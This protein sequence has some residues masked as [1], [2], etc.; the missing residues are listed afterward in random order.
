[1]RQ[2]LPEL[3]DARRQR[4]IREYAL[5][6]YDA[7]QLTLSRA[8]GGLFRGGGQGKRRAQTRRQLGAERTC[9]ICSRKRISE[10]TESPVSA[11]HLAELLRLIAKG[12][13]LRQD[14]EGYPGGDVFHGEDRRRSW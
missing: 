14:G 4:F 8:A 1:M 2:S 13:G 10:I 9:S 5:P 12:I 11:A 3:P 7:G 6:E